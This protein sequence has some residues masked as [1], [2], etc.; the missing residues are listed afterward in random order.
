LRKAIRWAR[1]I[2]EGDPSP[3][4]LA[5][6]AGDTTLIFRRAALL[7]EKEIAVDGVVLALRF[8]NGDVEQELANFPR[9]VYRLAQRIRVL[10]VIGS[11]A[12]AGLD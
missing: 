8:R 4:L 2:Q 1:A 12:R 6:R 11:R 5:A 10:P 9:G 3:E 7:G